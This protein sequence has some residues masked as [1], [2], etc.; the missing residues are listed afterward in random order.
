MRSNA[1]LEAEN[2]ELKAE[3]AM[4]AAGRAAQAAAAASAAAATS[5][6]KPMARSE[7]DAKPPH[8]RTALMRSGEYVLF[9]DDR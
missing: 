2:A 3:V 1:E 5:G 9:D 4:L 6:K 8:V 7:F